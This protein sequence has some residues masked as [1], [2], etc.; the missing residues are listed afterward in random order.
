MQ[1]NI[2][3]FGLYYAR[4]NVG[5]SGIAILIDDCTELISTCSKVLRDSTPCNINN[6]CLAIVE[7]IISIASVAEHYGINE[8]QIQFEIDKRITKFLT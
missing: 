1:F 3:D 5:Y 7:T 2:N 4:Q 8:S 6:M